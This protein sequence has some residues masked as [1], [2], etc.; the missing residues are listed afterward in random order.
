MLNVRHLQYFLTVAEMLNVTRAAERLHI[1]Q[2][3]LSKQISELERYL[4]VPLFLRGKRTLELTAAGKVL[5]REGRRLLSFEEAM[6]RKVAEAGRAEQAAGCG[7]LQLGYTGAMEAHG[8]PALARSFRSRYPDCAL[9]IQRFGQEELIARLRVGQE[10]AGLLMASG[11]EDAVPGL[12]QVT[13][14]SDPLCAVTAV[15]HPLAARPRVSL[16]E[17]AEEPIIL[18][19]GETIIQDCFLECCARAGLTPNI[20]MRQSLVESALLMVQSGFGITVLS[21]QISA[22]ASHGLER[23]PVRELP[24][25]YLTLGW[26]SDNPNPAIPLLV[27]AA[28]EVPWRAAGQSDQTAP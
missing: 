25:V 12:E 28:R 18:F 27:E 8:M 14:C 2:P 6:C 16:R 3:A 22:L 19:T 23:V 15:G 5:V 17:V 10:D 9:D 4:G 21:E 24:T 13:L 20:V 26:R 7:R 11:P 1:S